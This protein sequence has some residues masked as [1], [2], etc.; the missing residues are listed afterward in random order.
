[1]LL[2]SKGSVDAACIAMKQ[3]WAINLSGGFHHAERTGG[4]GFCIYPDITFVTHY[5]RKHYSNVK[6]ILI[7]D[8]DAHQGNGHERDH[9]GDKNTFIIDSYNHSIY[10]GDREAMKA[11]YIDIDVRYGDSDQQYLDDVNSALTKAFREKQIDFV[12]YN[13]GTDCLIG[14]PLGNCGLSEDGIIKRDEAVFEHCLAQNQTPCLMI[15]SGG[16]QQSNAQVISNSIQNLIKKFNLI[17]K[18][19]SQ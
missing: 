13:A 10:P 11:I 3:G 4:G 16:Y 18:F 9:L 8:L 12:V 7:I 17:Q 14:D 5:L 19:K 6:N 2:G 1:M 15:M